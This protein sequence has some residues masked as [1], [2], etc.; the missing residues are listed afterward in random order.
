MRVLVTSVRTAPRVH[1]DDSTGG[2]SPDVLAP[3]MTIVRRQSEHVWRRIVGLATS[4]AL[5]LLG[6]AAATGASTTVKAPG[7]IRVMV[8]GDFGR[9][10]YGNLGWSSAVATRLVATNLQGGV[11]DRRGGGH[12][13]VVMKC[14]S[15]RDGAD[16]CATRAVRAGVVAVL[17]M[18]ALDSAPIWPKLEAAHIAVIGSRV[19]TLADATSA[20]AFPL[21]PGLPGSFSAMPLALQRAGAH[22]VGVVI[23]DFGDATDALLGF[24]QQGLALT[25]GSLGP[26]VRVPLDATSLASA[27]QA[28]TQG[29]TDG[30]IGFVSGPKRGSLLRELAQV[31]Y[32][33]SYVTQ[34]PFGTTPLASDPDDSQAALLVGQFAPVSSDIP[35]MR[36]FQADM[37]ASPVGAELTRTEGAVNGWLAAWVFE[38]VVRRL[39]TVDAASVLR[40]MNRMQ[41]LD[42][43]GITPPLTTT[44]RDTSLPRM[45]N[46][47]VSFQYVL[48]GVTTRFTPEFVNAFDGTVVAP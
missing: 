48:R 19:N 30:V 35:G 41:G 14:D 37:E 13:V 21:S 9:G 33:G 1:M 24:I 8:I 15:G 45:F 6:T 7:A 44:G 28:V 17:G 47:T 27:A 43:G 12:R 4:V 31:G 3:R 40:A 16:A 23:S 2:G 32:T 20:V 38:R 36:E 22:T 26:V 39:A 11:V 18:N 34:A 5:L 46:P 25:G 42:M 10:R 29:G